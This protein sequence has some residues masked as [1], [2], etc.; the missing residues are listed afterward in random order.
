MSFSLA[1]D[2]S[3]G[4]PSQGLYNGIIA[5]LLPAGSAPAG[6]I[7][8]YTQRD[9][10]AQVLPT[11]LQSVASFDLHV[12]S[13]VPAPVLLRPIQAQLI[14][15]SLT[16][17]AKAMTVSL[18][19]HALPSG[20]TPGSLGVMWYDTSVG[21]WTFLPD[22]IDIATQTITFQTENLGALTLVGGVSHEYL[23]LVS[24]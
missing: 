10:P 5:V 11:S 19:Y 23:P 13:G 6:Y 18:S 1:A 15:I 12:F 7:F 3:G 22:I 8:E 2:I 21:R 16:S 4:S 24:R 17:L 20:V 9:S 14:P